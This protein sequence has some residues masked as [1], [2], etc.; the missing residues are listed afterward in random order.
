ML[1]TRG[2]EGIRVLP[3]QTFDG[4]YVAQITSSSRSVRI[5]LG[6]QISVSHVKLLNF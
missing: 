1:L 3:V 5:Q 2:Y 6:K 4:M